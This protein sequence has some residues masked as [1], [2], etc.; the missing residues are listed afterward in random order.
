M[1][2]EL[3]EGKLLLTSLTISEKAQIYAMAREIELRKTP[4]YFIDTFGAVASFIVAYGVGNHLNIKL[5]LFA[6][7]RPVRFTLYTLLGAFFGFNYIFIKDFSQ[8]HYEQKVDGNL[9]KKHPVF[10]EGGK[11]FYENILN[12]NIALRKLMGALGESRYTALGNENYLLRQRHLPLVQRRAF[13]ES[14]VESM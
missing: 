3:E 6:R 10:K 8:L 12:R 14:E 4:K 1:P 7:T 5:N 9:K 11:E 13:F 2:W